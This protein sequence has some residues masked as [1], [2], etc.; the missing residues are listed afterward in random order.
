MFEARLQKIAQEAILCGRDSTEKSMENASAALYFAC[1]Y[2]DKNK[3]CDYLIN[4]LGTFQEFKDF[5][6]D[7]ETYEAEKL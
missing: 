6:Q 2:H 4:N 5:Q 1:Y 3:S 7:W